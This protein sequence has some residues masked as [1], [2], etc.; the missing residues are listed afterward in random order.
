MGMKG[1]VQR[2][3]RSSLGLRGGGRFDC[4]V[5]GRTMA[6]LGGGV[7]VV[8]GLVGLV[9]ELEVVR[10]VGSARRGVEGWRSGR[11]GGLAVGVGEVV[12]GVVGLRR[13][14]RWVDGLRGGGMRVRFSG[15]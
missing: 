5:E 4:G 9:M 10:V 11:D 14:W 6:W 15:A 2:L 7:V 8:V 13:C 3:Q 12:S 1:R